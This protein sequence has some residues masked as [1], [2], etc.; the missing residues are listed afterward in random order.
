MLSRVGHRMTACSASATSLCAPGYVSCAFIA[1]SACNS[2]LAAVT[3]LDLHLTFMLLLLVLHVGQLHAQQTWT[4]DDSLLSV[5]HIPLRARVC[6]LRF[7]RI[8]RLQL[9]L[10]AV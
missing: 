10:A 2:F 7:Y 3:T 1:S 9:F 8:E 5:R 4:W 6:Q